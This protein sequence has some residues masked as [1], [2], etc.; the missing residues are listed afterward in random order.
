[1]HTGF[2]GDLRERCHLEDLDVDRKIIQLNPVI[3][4]SVYITPRL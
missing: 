4:T 2:R 3:T 1:V